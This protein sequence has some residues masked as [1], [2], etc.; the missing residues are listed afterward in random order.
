MKLVPAQ[1]NGIARNIFLLRP[2]PAQQIFHLKQAVALHKLP[3]HHI[4]GIRLA[5]FAQQ[6]HGLQAVAAL[7][8]EIPL[9]VIRRTQHPPAYL[10]QH[11]INRLPSHIPVRRRIHQPFQGIAVYLAGHG[12]GHGVQHM[13]AGRD[14]VCG[15]IVFAPADDLLKPRPVAQNQKP[16]QHGLP[17]RVFGGYGKRLAHAPAAFEQKR[18]FAQLH[19]VATNLHLIIAPAHQNNLAR[20]R[21]HG[22][23]TCG[24]DPLVS[25][26][27][28]ALLDGHSA[29]R[30]QLAKP[31]LRQL[32]VPVIAKGHA[33]TAYPQFPC[34]SGGKRLPLGIQNI[35]RSVGD[36][37]PYAYGQHVIR[38]NPLH[39][40]AHAGLRRTVGVNI[41]QPARVMQGIFRH[42]RLTCRNQH[43]QTGKFFLVE[44]M[45]V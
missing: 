39:G 33:G 4:H 43:P 17:G 38:R 31:Q 7:I 16:G 21:P 25:L 6:R 41:F 18:H 14:H 11:R 27:S 1:G 23:I 34:H 28:L 26:V 12:H 37:P 36:G 3:E 5:Q 44:H 22:H 29:Q 35:G 8:E 45:Q 32:S 24:I 10:Q 40:G 42:G 9:R 19:P 30:R 13:P 20:L 2:A 15:Q